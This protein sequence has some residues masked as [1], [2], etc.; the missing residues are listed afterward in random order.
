MLSMVLGDDSPLADVS[1]VAAQVTAP[2]VT[3]DEREDTKA[4]WGG[5]KKDKAPNIDRDFVGAHKQ[6]VK[7]C[8]SG[9]NS[10]CNEEQFERRFRM[11]HVIF[12]KICDE[13]IGNPDT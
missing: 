4:Q 8:F 6:L 11:K 3:H 9:Q 2:A 1:T 13:T 5:S 10:L 7:H 12:N